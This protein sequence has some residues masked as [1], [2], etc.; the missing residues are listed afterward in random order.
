MDVITTRAGSSTL[1]FMRG[2]GGGAI[3]LAQA[4][5]LPRDHGSG[6]RNTNALMA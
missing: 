5:V 2:D 6:Q 1:N 4:L 3:G